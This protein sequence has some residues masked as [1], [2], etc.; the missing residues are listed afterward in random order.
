MIAAVLS[1]LTPPMNVP[2]A[3][4]KGKS[5]PRLAKDSFP[6]PHFPAQKLSPSPLLGLPFSRPLA[7][8]LFSPLLLPLRTSKEEED[9]KAA[10]FRGLDSGSGPGLLLGGSV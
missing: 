2:P 3:R 6:A 7:R 1:A 4:L 10:A 8:A 5:A 9:E